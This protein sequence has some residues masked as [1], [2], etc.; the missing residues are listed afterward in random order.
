QI[1]LHVVGHRRPRARSTLA[2]HGGNSD[3]DQRPLN[4]S[5]HVTPL[6][7]S[8]GKAARLV[9]A[10]GDQRIRHA[11][12]HRL[13]TKLCGLSPNHVIRVRRTAS[14]KPDVSVHSVSNAGPPS[15]SWGRRAVG[16]RQFPAPASSDCP[17]WLPVW[18]IA[19]QRL[20]RPSTIS[21]LALLA[22]SL[23]SGC[24]HATAPDDFR[25]AELEA[26]RQKWSDRG[27]T[28]Y[29]FT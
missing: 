29:T 25:Q 10:T 14:E 1:T 18:Q 16:S 3:R 12:G 2:R 22:A 11:T 15:V 8:V 7:P 20:V 24:S 4:D 5:S 19:I 23:M 13:T 17:G 27:Y 9:R 6:S 21:R 26:N 28:N